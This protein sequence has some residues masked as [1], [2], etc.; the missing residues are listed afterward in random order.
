[1]YA[2]LPMY[3]KKKRGRGGE[4]E[5]GKRGAD[6]RSLFFFGGSRPAARGYKKREKGRRKKKKGGEETTSLLLPHLYIT[7]DRQCSS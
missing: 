6:Y 4:M 7:L 3:R 1:M 5:K 2:A